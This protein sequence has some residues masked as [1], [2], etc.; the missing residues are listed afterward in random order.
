MLFVYLHIL[1][2]SPDQRHDK[3]DEKAKGKNNLALRKV[4]ALNL[5]KGIC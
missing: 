2:V 1:A 4:H 5:N 3:G